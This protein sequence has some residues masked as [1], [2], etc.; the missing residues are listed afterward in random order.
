MAN[1][2]KKFLSFYKNVY[3]FEPFKESYNLLN[4]NIGANNLSNVCAIDRSLDDINGEELF[5]Y[6]MIFFGE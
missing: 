4:E 5:T 2:K 3:A 1:F 6:L